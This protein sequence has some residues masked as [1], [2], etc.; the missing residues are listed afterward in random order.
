MNKLFVLAALLITVSCGAVQSA[1]PDQDPSP[2]FSLHIAAEQDTV[3]AGSTI[4]IN[5][6][7]AN[8]TDHEISVF[9]VSGGFGENFSVL[10]EKGKTVPPPKPEIAKDG[11]RIYRVR[12]GSPVTYTHLQVGKTVR[13]DSGPLN[14]LFDFSQPGKYTIQA[15]CTDESTKSVVKSNQI[16]LTVTQ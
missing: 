16:V 14:H 2:S 8:T 11:R 12:V 13:G 6:T 7:L 10:D 1:H 4:Q 9:L 15:Q 5:L 3:K